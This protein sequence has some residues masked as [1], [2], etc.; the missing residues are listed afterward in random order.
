MGLKDRIK[1]RL[2]RHGGPSGVLKAALGRKGSG[3]STRDNNDQLSSYAAA[4]A[5]LPDGADAD[6]FIAVAARGLVQEGR[7]STFAVNG[8][9]IA[10]YQ[11]EDRLYA[12]DSAC[13]HEDG[14]L[15]ES[16]V[17]DGV[18]T[19]PYHDWRFELQTGHCVTDPSRPVATYAIKE[20]EGFIWIG[21]ALSQGSSQRGGEH[22]DGMEMR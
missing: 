4:T 10:V 6:G 15:G 2:D 12:I 16:E 22:D 11:W 1:R 13:S 17:E 14:P 5:Q 8:K 19:C 9:N 21:A 7:P 20:A 3:T 18:I